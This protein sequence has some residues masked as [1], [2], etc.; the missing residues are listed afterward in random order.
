MSVENPVDMWIMPKFYPENSVISTKCR[1]PTKSQFSDK[2][3][4]FHLTEIKIYY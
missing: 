3:K 2:R 1:F 4:V